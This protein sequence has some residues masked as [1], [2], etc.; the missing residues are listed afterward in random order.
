M[1]N[2]A[3]AYSSFWLSSVIRSPPSIIYL[4]VNQHYPLTLILKYFLY[5]F[6]IDSSLCLHL[7]NICTPFVCTVYY[8]VYTFL[9]YICLLV[10]LWQHPS[11]ELLRLS[12]WS[13]SILNPHTAVIRPSDL[14][15]AGCDVA[16]LSTRLRVL[17]SRATTNSTV[18]FGWVIN[19]HGGGI[20][21]C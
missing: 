12:V 11:T 7:S 19:H 15:V 3:E 16:S 1:K 8:A 21:S 6:C 9:T 14:C 5:N 17:S 4:S 20:H 18:A 13:Y 10:S 2:N